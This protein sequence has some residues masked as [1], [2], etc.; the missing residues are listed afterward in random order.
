[1]S[2]PRL[3]FRLTT[4]VVSQGIETPV[5]VVI[6][7]PIKWDAVRIT[8]ERDPD[9][10]GFLYEYSDGKIQLDF[11]CESAGELLRA[12]YFQY[13]NDAVVKLLLVDL[14]TNGDESVRYSGK[15]DF[16]N[17]TLGIGK[18]SADVVRDDLNQK[19]TSRFDT[20]VSMSVEKTLDNSPITPPSAVEI[21]LPGQALKESGLFKR[22]GPFTNSDRFDDPAEAGFYAFFPNLVAVP[23]TPGN[24]VGPIDPITGQPS[25][26]KADLSSMKGVSV[27]TGQS[28]VPGVGEE[29]PFIGPTEA[30]GE[31]SLRFIW[32]Y[33][34]EIVIYK[35]A[36]RIGGALFL[37]WEMAPVLL[38]VRPGKPNEVIQIGNVAKG[39]GNRNTTGVQS[40]NCDYTGSFS[41]PKGTRV[42]LSTQ[43]RAFV[44]GCRSIIFSQQVLNVKVELTRT[45]RAVDSKGYAFLLPDALKHVFGVVSNA[46]T[47]GTGS[48]GGSLISGASMAQAQPGEATD[49]AVSSGYQL[50]NLNTKAPTFS[51]KQLMGTLSALNVAGLLYETDSAGNH[52][53][54]VESGEWFYRGGEILVLD[55]VAED[56]PIIFAYSETPN[57]D[58][59]VNQIIVGY[60]KYPDTGPGALLEFNTERTYQTP[61]VTH[62]LT[63]EIKCPLIGAGAAIEEARRL[64]IPTYDTNGK[65]IDRS[66]EGGTYDDDN[67]ILH[68]AAKT[69]TATV[70]F[71]QLFGGIFP[72]KAKTRSLIAFSDD[73]NNATPKLKAGDKLTISGSGTTNDGVAFTVVNVLL[74]GRTNSSGQIQYELSPPAPTPTTGQL[75]VQYGLGRESVRIRTNERIDVSGIPDAGST[76]NLELSPARM[77]RRWAAFLNSGFRYKNPTDELRCTNYIGNRDMISRVRD[78]VTLPGDIDRQNV[79]ETGDIA[80]GEF[81]GFTALFS[82]EIITTTVYMSRDQLNELIAALTNQHADDSKNMGYITIRR[83]NGEIAEAYP[84][85]ISYNPN[86][87]VCELTLRKKFAVSAISGPA[88][89]DY[90]SWVIGRFENDPTADKNL[91]RFCRFKDFL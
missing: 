41:A 76:Y 37:L 81:N 29:L 39:G 4:V 3:E 87:D 64:G 7:E 40:I 61:I 72:L 88:C 54:R 43:I 1:M 80:L 55:E 14:L 84:D 20:P 26:A 78:G 38:I 50:R 71:S 59:L 73:R 68:V 27:F 18:F 11:A 67:F 90:A 89:Q 8:A 77:V 58:M 47:N 56:E 24:P 16:N 79:Y 34:L 33:R 5:S 52:S 23:G 35:K 70:V 21:G 62:Q 74:M 85:K 75:T 9:F 10:H 60:E 45:T 44:D 32:S 22:I 69:T 30:D 91:Y 82:P 25:P 15:I 28:V 63:K 31:Y 66:T 36:L 6:E 46:L 19:I 48:V 51:F 13:G 17:C 49:Y 86:Q 53:V 57:T 12:Q 65:A 2:F 42:Y 83:A